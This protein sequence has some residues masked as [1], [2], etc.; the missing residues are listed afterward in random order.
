MKTFGILGL[1]LIAMSVG[2]AAVARVDTVLPYAISDVW[3]TT[4]R[5]VRL[6]R[7]YTMKERDE[8]AGYIMFEV[9]EGPRVYR[10]SIEL[11]RTRDNDGRDATR[12]LLTLPEMPRHWEQTM[13]EKL[14]AKVKDEYGSPPPAPR[15]PPPERPADRNRPRPD[16]GT[17]PPLP[18]PR[19]PVR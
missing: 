10:G 18:Q 16:A 3:P 17:P 2:P 9:H 8:E 11:V 19:P 6:D 7:G 12:V 14:T 1:V 5:F 4:I 13:L 15:R